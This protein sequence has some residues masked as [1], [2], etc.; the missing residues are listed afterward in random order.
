MVSQRLESFGYDMPD[1]EWKK[2]DDRYPFC[3]GQRN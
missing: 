2:I 3:R 1:A